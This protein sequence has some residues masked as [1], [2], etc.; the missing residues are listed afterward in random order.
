MPFAILIGTTIEFFDCHS[1][2]TERVR[3]PV[4]DVFRSY[5]LELVLGLLEA[6]PTFCSSTC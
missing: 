5:P 3:V 2:A 6:M 4:I 1:F